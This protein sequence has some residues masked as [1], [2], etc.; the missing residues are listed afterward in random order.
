M[1]EVTNPM[2]GAG[3]FLYLE[4]KNIMDKSVEGRV[5]YS[6]FNNG[7]ETIPLKD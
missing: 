3:E 2:N 7:L 4:E 6:G 1:K 5:L